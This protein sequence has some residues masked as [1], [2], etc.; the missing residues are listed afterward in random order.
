M[1]AVPE[2]P[3]TCPVKGRTKKLTTQNML[4]KCLPCVESKNHLEKLTG[5]LEHMIEN[6]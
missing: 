6:G 4:S 5:L 1:Y 2:K 3:H